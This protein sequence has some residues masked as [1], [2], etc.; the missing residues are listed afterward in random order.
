MAFD[1]VAALV[2]WLPGKCGVPVSSKVPEERPERFVTVERTGGARSIGSDRPALAVQAWAQTD[3]EA[4]Q[5][6]LGCADA[7][8]R[9]CARE[10]PQVCR[11]TV[12]GVYDFPDPDSRQSRQQLSVYMVTRP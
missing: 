5:L 1:A 6:A 10:I 9:E 3:A 4:A 11:C 8:V 12:E 2:A 7:L